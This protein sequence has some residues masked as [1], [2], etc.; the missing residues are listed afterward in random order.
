MTDPAEFVDK[1]T[2]QV[3][4]WKEARPI[5]ERHIREG[6]GTSDGKSNWDARAS[7]KELFDALDALFKTQQNIN[8]MMLAALDELK[9]Q[10]E[11]QQ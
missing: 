1:F 11:V 7:T 8:V 10:Q 5:W 3:K 9:S 2:E 4:Q 6:Y